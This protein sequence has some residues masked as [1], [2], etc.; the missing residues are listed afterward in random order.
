MTLIS[1]WSDLS[2]FKSGEWQ[3]IQERLH[4]QKGSYAPPR[5]LLF[6]GLYRVPPRKVRVLV[7]G[8]DPYPTEGDADGVAFSVRNA[9]WPDL[10]PTLK[11]IFQE[12]Q[13]DLGYPPP[14]S[15]DLTPWC[16]Q[17]VLLWNAYPSCALGRPGSHHWPEW[18][19][20]TAEILNETCDRSMVYAL[21]GNAAGRWANYIERLHVRPIQ[22]D[23]SVFP[24]LARPADIRPHS[25]IQ[26]SHPSP[27]GARR[28]FIGSRLFSHINAELEILGQTPIN[29]RLP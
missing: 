6:R 2:F 14:Y 16:D 20:L 21:L 7:L 5:H 1:K 11:N 28:G 18:D 25:I 29:W 10:P 8:Q 4:D 3:V 13:D 12:Y 24:P 9:R 22:W 26:S 17:G 23:E 27:L 15:G 19:L